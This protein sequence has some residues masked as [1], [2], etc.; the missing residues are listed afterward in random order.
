MGSP[1]ILIRP[2]REITGDALFNG[3]FLEQRLRPRRDGG[4]QRE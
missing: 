1:G 2:L 4:R 3:V